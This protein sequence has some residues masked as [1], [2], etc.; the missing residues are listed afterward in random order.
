[1]YDSIP[2]DG[3]LNA[4]LQSFGLRALPTYSF[5]K[6]NIIVSFGAD[7]LGNWLNND[8]SNDYIKA[9]NP[10]NAKMSKHYQIEQIYH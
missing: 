8:Y 2:F 9:R 7:F 4:N 10:K 1:M 5:D 6:A 3:M